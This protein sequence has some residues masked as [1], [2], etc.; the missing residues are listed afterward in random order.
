MSEV[1]VVTQKL[2]MVVIV[3]KEAAKGTRSIWKWA[4]EY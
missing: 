1:E 4:S 3:M 2:R